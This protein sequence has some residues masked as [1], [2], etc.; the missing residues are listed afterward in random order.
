[1]LDHGTDPVSRNLQAFCNLFQNAPVGLMEDH[2][3]HVLDVDPELLHHISHGF[4]HPPDR[5]PK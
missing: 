1:V 4:F 5:L 3:S 2:L